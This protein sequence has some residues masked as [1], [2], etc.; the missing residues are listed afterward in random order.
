ML[1]YNKYIY[2]YLVFSY[3]GINSGDGYVTIVPALLPTGIQQTM[4]IPSYVSSIYFTICGAAGGS[5]TYSSTT[6]SSGGGGI[7]IRTIVPVSS[8]KL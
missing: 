3:I 7:C 4:T 1:S 5:Y 6:N 2:I 8:G